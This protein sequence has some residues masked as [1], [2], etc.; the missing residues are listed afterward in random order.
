MGSSTN[1]TTIDRRRWRPLAGRRPTEDRPPPREAATPPGASRRTPRLRRAFAFLALLA[2]ACAAAPPAAAQETVAVSNIG[3]TTED[4]HDLQAQE[5]QAQGFRTGT[6]TGGY[7]LTSIELKV[8]DVTVSSSDLTVSLRAKDANSN[9]PTL[10]DLVV[11]T[12]PTLASDTTLKWTLPSGTSAYALS[13]STRYFVVVRIASGASGGFEWAFTEAT[14]E[15]SGGAAGWTIDDVSRGG[16]AGMWDL[17]NPNAYQIRVNARVSNSP[18]SG[19]PT[20]SGT[21]E[22]GSTL[23]AS[24]SAVMDANGRPQIVNFQWVRVDG[25]EESDISGAEEPEY[26]LQS[27]DRGKK[28][29]VKVSF[30]DDDGYEEERV[31]DA[32]PGTGTVAA[33]DRPPGGTGV[34]VSNIGRTAGSTINAIVSQPFTTGSSSAGYTLKS[35]QLVVTGFLSGVPS[36]RRKVLVRIAPSN[37]S[38]EPDLSDSS[39]VISLRTPNNITSTGIRTFSAPSDSRLAGNTTY[40]VVV[41]NHTANGVPTATLQRTDSH[42]E[43]SGRAPGWTIGNALLRKGN[44]SD[45]WDSRSQVLRI[46][47]NGTIRNASATGTPT[48]SGTLK[49]GRTLTANADDIEDENGLDNASFRYQWIMVFGDGGEI[50]IPNATGRKFTIGADRLGYKLKVR[51]SFRD[52]AGFSESRTSAA[53]GTIPRSIDET[54]L[55]DN[56]DDPDDFNG[57]TRGAQRA[58]GFRTAGHF[59]EY[60][61][62]SVRI[63]FAS[64]NTATDM[65]VEIWT[66]TYEGGQYEVGNHKTY[67]RKPG[68]FLYQMENPS[69]LSG[70]GLKTFEAPDGAVLKPWTSY[71]VVVKQAGGT[72]PTLSTT[73]ERDP[74][75]GDGSGGFA[76]VSNGRWLR[77]SATQDWGFSPGAMGIVVRGKPRLYNTNAKLASIEVE[78]EHGDSYEVKS[79]T[80][81]LGGGLQVIG[82]NFNRSFTPT[83]KTHQVRVPNRVESVTLTADPDDDK[84]SVVDFYDQSRPLQQRGVGSWSN[85]RPGESDDDRLS[86][87]FDVKP[88]R[89]EFRLHVKAEDVRVDREYVVQV[90]RDQCGANDIWCGKM[91]VGEFAT[92]VG[93]DK[94]FGYVEDAFGALSPATFDYDGTE[95]TVDQLRLLPAGT[96]QLGIVES[97]GS[98]V[99]TFDDSAFSLRID[100]RSFPLAGTYDDIQA[101]YRLTGTGIAW[102]DGERVLVR[103][104][105]GGGGGGGGSGTLRSLESNSAEPLIASLKRAPDDHDGEEPFRVRVAFSEDIATSY[106]VLKNGFAVTGGAITSVKRVD[107]RSDLWELEVSPDGDDDVTLVLAA[108]QACT[109]EGAPCT[110]DIPPRQLA[111]TLTVTVPGPEDETALTAR[112]H[113]NPI[114][115]DG[116][117]FDVYIA[118]SAPITAGMSK[119][120]QAF[121][122]TDGAVERTRRV[123]G[124]SDLWRVRVR[125]DGFDDVKVLLRGNRACGSGGVPCA[126]TE[127]GEGRIPLSHDLSVIVRGQPAISVADAE[128]TEGPGATMAFKVSLDKPVLDT[129]TVDYATR[130][131][132]A[133]AGSDYTAKS[134][135]LTFNVGNPRTQTV[136]VEV[137]N[138]AHNDDGETFEL[139]L[140]NPSGARIADG[141]ATGTI[142]NS[143]AI[144]RAW[145]ARFGRTVADQVLEAV[146]ERMGAS[147]APGLEA[148]LAG[149]ALSFDAMPEDAE[150]LEAR[151]E[152]TR[153]GALA[154][155]LR[156]TDGEADRAALSGTRT[157][158]EREL[159][160]GTSFA[161]TGGTPGERTVSAWGRGEVS[162]FDGREGDLGLDGEVGNLMLGADFTRGRATAGLV[163]SHA[164]GSGGYRGASSGNVEADLTGLYPW[165]RYAVSERVSVWGVAGYGAGTL[166]VEPEGQAALETGMDLAM[167]SVG[168]RGVLLE[169]PAEG[170]AELAV[171]SDAMAVRSTSDAVSGDTGNLAGSEVD[172]TRL[173]L[174]VEGSRAF[175]FGDGASLV[176]SVEL[177][178]RRDGGDAETG[179][180]AD[181]GAG[182]AWSDPARGLSAE[183]RARGLLTHE[184]GSFSERGFAGSLAW[185][186]APESA[187][188]PSFSL[189]QTVGARATGGMEALLRP[190]TATALEAANDAGS[191]SGTGHDRNG[192]ERRALEARLGYGFALAGGRYTGTPEFRLGLTDSSRELVLGW[193][194]VEEARTGLAFG[195]DV[196]GARQESAAGE[197]G[198]RLGL[199]FGW[200]L[201]GEGAQ[202]FELR[203]EG[204]RLEPANDGA[205][206]RVGATLTARW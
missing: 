88:G 77:G 25:S 113:D 30:T 51:V 118:F 176:P 24:A 98:P 141:T 96:L 22:V 149:Q 195:L 44:I 116:S 16:F 120:P 23:R 101:D 111:N 8:G 132:T 159:L 53:T 156:G 181:I 197:A 102:K 170:G 11:F 69:G 161:L 39:K 4:V 108:G 50:G 153:A 109:V 168:V 162:H 33:S 166:A 135:T 145:M 68:S 17:S 165:G 110:G 160:A 182:L 7:S 31:S 54:D 134:G 193:R 85:L 103:L 146:D 12:N 79:G 199:G 72:A 5:L 130:D 92:G 59:P 142:H 82:H 42:S 190:Q 47:I 90:V 35:V 126:K 97:G 66:T 140:S 112:V 78:D 189:S 45:A 64:G 58:Q 26:E 186:P 194:L 19:K 106:R 28:V 80:E 37:S 179:F 60:E 18:A 203:F 192:L 173:R 95:H 20:I 124:R 164:R 138:D 123:N 171:T 52:D 185:D 150:A 143:D 183:M 137:R 13:A 178:V 61:F 89:N 133:V 202:A 144:P 200:R 21:A 10:T 63:R 38:D 105:R 174:G 86:Q 188:G 104:V 27:A 55:V 201:E 151:E 43:D 67:I 205:E 87:R 2:L 167:A 172:V 148:T 180:G 196:E 131:G 41:T 163:L 71:A 206:H 3:K 75:D 155:W 129:V 177:G 91:T 139:V 65:D 175:R 14:G 115:H 198:H 70:G 152:Q 122:V 128:A 15:D 121:D 40:H 117:P 81:I 73:A 107:K 204:S 93:V 154:A 36:E 49:L 127:D 119:F 114:E 191:G 29:K 136:E 1:C 99:A 34:L 48:I 74:S 157:V 84:A 57:T 184:D 100:G 83:L 76:Y 187:R 9:L 62:E 147:R 46:R 169:A 32:F 6:E 158:S 125:P 94:H 56:A